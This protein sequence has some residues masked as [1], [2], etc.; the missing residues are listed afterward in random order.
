MTTQ[1]DLL[2]IL[3]KEIETALLVLEPFTFSTQIP[4]FLLFLL[5]ERG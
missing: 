1:S 4:T 5:F 2:S 3:V